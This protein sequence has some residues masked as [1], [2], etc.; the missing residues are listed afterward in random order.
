MSEKSYQRSIGVKETLCSEGQAAYDLGAE[1]Q[2]FKAEVGVSDDVEKFNRGV[3]VSFKVYADLNVDGVEDSSEMVASAGAQYGRPA[4][5]DVS[6][7]G[8]RRIILVVATPFG[9]MSGT[10]V[11]AE[12]Q[13]Y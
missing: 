10:A 1:Y 3:S 12:P 2:R 5:I 13:V 4:H 6:I 11:W 8:A 7:K 9:C